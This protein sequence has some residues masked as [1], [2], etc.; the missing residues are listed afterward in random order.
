MCLW[1]QAARVLRQCS[2]SI[3]WVKLS[4]GR[5]GI[6]NS[7]RDKP[8]CCQQLCKM[9]REYLKRHT[10]TL[11]CF[12]F[13]L[14]WLKQFWRLTANSVCKLCGEHALAG[15]FLGETWLSS[16]SAI[17]LQSLEFRKT[18]GFLWIISTLDT[19]FCYQEG[20]EPPR[21]SKLKFY[22]LKIVPINN[23]SIQYVLS[24]S[25]T[26]AFYEESK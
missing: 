4:V 3:H 1:G 7:A 13:I 2:E 25:S 17:C 20:I 19:H 16:R 11:C 23:I 5:K 14:P 21:A 6:V 9:T 26:I 18:Q 24:H 10:S 22:V 8:C 15:E 12:A